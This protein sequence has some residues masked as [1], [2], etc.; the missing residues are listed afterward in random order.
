MGR[1]K[2]EHHSMYNRPNNHGVSIDIDTDAKRK[3]SVAIL[4]YCCN[5]TGDSYYRNFTLLYSLV[6]E[7]I[8]E[9]VGQLYQSDNDWFSLILT[10]QKSVF[11]YFYLYT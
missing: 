10:S 8:F 5:W 9:I 3:S 11:L 1:E 4:C 6:F 7:C 2:G